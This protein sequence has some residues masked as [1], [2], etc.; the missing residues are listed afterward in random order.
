MCIEMHGGLN[1]SVR[2]ENLPI[3]AKPGEV[4]ALDAGPE[5]EPVNPVFEP[6]M[7]RGDREKSDEEQQE[8]PVAGIVAF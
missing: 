4:L 7:I 1:R 2:R 3:K 6:V 5:R 8:R